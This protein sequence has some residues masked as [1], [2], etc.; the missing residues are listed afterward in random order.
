MK[1]D[2]SV[3]DI[4]SL[5]FCDSADPIRR[6]TELFVHTIYIDMPMT[7]EE[8]NCLKAM[9]YVQDVEETRSREDLA[10]GF[11]VGTTVVILSLVA[12]R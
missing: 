2:L 5:N 9:E 12:L 3:C 7:D 11:G 1:Q 8:E 6:S 10:I 4:F